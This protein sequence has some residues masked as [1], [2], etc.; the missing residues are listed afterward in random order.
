MDWGLESENRFEDPIITRENLKDRT[1]AED[2]LRHRLAKLEELEAA[3]R[4][5]ATRPRRPSG[6]TQI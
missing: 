4:R 6:D 2:I 1:N 3:E 5:A